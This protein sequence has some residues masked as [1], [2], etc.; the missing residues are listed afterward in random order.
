MNLCGIYS[1]YKNMEP[2]EELELQELLQLDI[3]IHDSISFKCGYEKGKRLANVQ[4]LESEIQKVEER[5][6]EYLEMLSKSKGKS[7]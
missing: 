3:N 5:I 6:N 2:K 4:M 1:Y 7:H